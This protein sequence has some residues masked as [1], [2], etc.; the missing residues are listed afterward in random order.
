TGARTAKRYNWA[1]CPV[2][3]GSFVLSKG[4]HEIILE[5][6]WTRDYRKTSAS[7]NCILVNDMDQWRDGQVGHP[8][9][10][11]DQVAPIVFCADGDLLSAAR[12][13]LANA[14]PPEAKLKAISCC[15]VHIRPDLFLVFDRVETAGK[16]KAEWRYHAAYL[17]P[18]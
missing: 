5:A 4:R 14:C 12:T 15:L 18:M 7:N 3:Q 2:N 11:A 17:D 6:G 13:D 1:H 10:A 16:G 9:L 8:R